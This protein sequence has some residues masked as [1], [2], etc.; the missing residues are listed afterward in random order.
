MPPPIV[1]IRGAWLSADCWND[2]RSRY[3][4][5][6]HRCLVPAW[7]GDDL[8][9]AGPSGPSGATVRTIARLIQHY[10]AVVRA[11]PEAPVLIGHGLGGLVVQSLLDYG[12]GAAGVGLSAWPPNG[13]LG[14]LFTL[15]TAVPMVAA[16]CNWHRHL[17]LQPTL[18]ARTMAQTLT[19][20]RQEGYYR[21]FV[22]PAPRRLVTDALFGRGTAVSADNHN[23]APLLLIAAE[24]DRLVTPATVQANCRWQ[25]RSG[26]ET[27]FRLFPGR[28]H[29]LIAEPGWTDIAD[30]CRAWAETRI[31]VP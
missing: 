2:W 1:F 27:A 5:T 19:T 3:E 9:A 6:G 15:G 25:R 24:H 17:T 18:F 29:L 16:A 11:L 30:Y 14:G 13:L 26:A 12:L 22:V 21:R 20:S 10:A 28:S 8:P 7:P 4:R 31:I 23:R